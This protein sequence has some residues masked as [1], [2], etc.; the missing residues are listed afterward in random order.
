MLLEAVQGSQ[1]D[2]QDI[3]RKDGEKREEDAKEGKMNASAA[4]AYDVALRAVEP[5]RVAAIRGVVPDME[6]TGDT[7]D[8]LFGILEECVERNGGA[9]GPHMAIYHDAGTGPWKL[10][11][12]IELA[13]PF[14]GA[15]FSAEHVYVHELPSVGQMACVVH[16]GPFEEIGNAYNAVMEWARERGYHVAGPS[17]EIYLS[18]GDGDSAKYVTEVQIPMAR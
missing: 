15:G 11:M 2:E 17:R 13:V 14:E 10:D 4:V 9:A 3:L 5:I 16:N 18:C 1:P 7:F 12:R 8:R 6:Q